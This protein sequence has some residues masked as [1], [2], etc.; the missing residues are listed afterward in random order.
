MYRA[1]IDLYGQGDSRYTQYIWP[2]WMIFGIEVW[3]STVMDKKGERGYGT[4]QA[5]SPFRYDGKE[6]V[7]HP[8]PSGV[9]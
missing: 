3:L 1:M 7:C 2:L 4:G 8:V 5:P 6:A 9:R